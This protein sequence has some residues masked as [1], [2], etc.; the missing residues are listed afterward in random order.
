MFASLRERSD[1][2]GSQRL[3]RND[4]SKTQSR[5]PGQ[6]ERSRSA[7]G[8]NLSTLTG[9]QAIVDVTQVGLASNFTEAKWGGSPLSGQRQQRLWAP[10][11]S[12]RISIRD[13]ERL[14]NQV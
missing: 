8:I 10:D 3:I 12:L 11:P 5:L 14:S 13:H 1:G 9:L 2:S 4:A 6:R 7:F